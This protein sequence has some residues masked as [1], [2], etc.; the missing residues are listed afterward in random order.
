MQS[1]VP[2]LGHADPESVV[3][4]RA[5]RAVTAAQFLA[6]VGRLASALPRAEHVINACADRYCFAVALAAALSRA[7]VSLLPADLT[8]GSLRQLRN[9]YPGLYA[10]CDSQLA[11]EGI[12][13]VRVDPREE[14]VTGAAPTLV[15]AAEQPAVVAF[16]SGSTGRPTPNPK[17]WGALARG[18]VAEAQVLGLAGAPAATL[19]GTVPPQHMYGLES[20][21]LLALRNGLSLHAARPF[22]PADVRAVLEEL[23]AAR[24]LVTTPVH[25]RALLEADIDLP[26][27]RLAVCATAPLSA[28]LAARFESR[29][30]VQLREI[31]GFTEA[32][33]VATRRTV[34]GPVWHALPG[35][36][37]RSEQG[38]VWVG[39]GHVAREVPF[40]DVVEPRDER[41]FELVGR[42][43][44]LV[45]IAGKRTSLAFLDHQLNSIPGVRDAAFFLPEESPDGI[46][47]PLA[48]VVA[49]G[50]ARDTLI[51][52]LRARVDAVFLPRPLYFVEALPRNAAGKLPREALVELASRCAEGAGAQI[53]ARISPEH[54]ALAGH[55]PGDPVVPGAVLLDELVAA[56]SRRFG[57]ARAP[58][59]MGAKFLRPVRPGELLNI[60]LT[61]TGPDAIRFECR[62]AGKAAVSGLLRRGG[63]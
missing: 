52:Q 17:S 29:H 63:A 9:G 23:P 19:V 11:L 54:P 12:E 24:V 32:G 3:A 36:H 2:F 57:W 10:L 58:L 55:F 59:T 35:V 33:M 37:L 28:E 47:R 40:T 27:L 22:Y 5:G 61:P 38:T 46:V 39:G 31:Y 13:C 62:V 26:E 30:R 20:T 53:E 25:L 15:F 49:P 6:H 48:F 34:E 56:V 4:W 7:Q 16:T 21:V 45:N 41:R 44:D 50:L 18:A 51:E 60:H 14:T 43:A 8:P 42:G 1:P